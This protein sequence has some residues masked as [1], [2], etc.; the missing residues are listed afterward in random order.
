LNGQSTI[1]RRMSELYAAERPGAIIAV[2]EVPRELTALYGVVDPE[3]GGA[4]FGIRDLVEKPSPESAPSN[5]AIAG[6]YI[7]SPQIF[8]MIRGVE[9]DGKGEIQLTDAIRMLARRGQRILGVKLDPSERRYD[10]GNF[11]SYFETFVE[12]ALADPDYGSDLRQVLQRLLA[13]VQ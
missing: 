7:F 13:S 3:S 10:I 4:V 8:Q 12:F 5:L 9:P 1:S 11:R 2:E 6:R